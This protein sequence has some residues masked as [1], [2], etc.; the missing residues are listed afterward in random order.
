[1]GLFGGGSQKTTTK[2]SPW[3]PAIPYLKGVLSGAQD[4]YDKGPLKY[5]PGSTVAPQSDGS[6]TAL[7]GI[8]QRGMNGSPVDTAAEHNITGVLNGD[9]LKAGNPYFGAM[10][11]RIMGQ[12]MPA[13]Q[14][15]FSMAGRTGSGLNQEALAQGLGDSIGALAFQNYNSERD[16][17]MDSL[18]LAPQ[19]AHED[20]VNMGNAANAA[21]QQ[22]GYDQRQLTDKVNR[23][24]FEQQAPGMALDQF[25]GRVDPIGGMGSQTTS[26]T[27]GG[28]GGLF[29]NLLGTALVG[30]NIA[31][32]LN[33]FG[34]GA[35]GAAGAAGS[36]PMGLAPMAGMANFGM[37][38]WY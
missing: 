21:Q 7:Q 38:G 3:K 23:W 27:S 5:Y 14:S 22:E 9:F 13:I 10:S 17:Q 19:I 1:M 32:K 26:T 24:N 33:L 6:R 30:S 36:A 20:F 18:G 28:G 4:L 2:V 37:G 15:Q 25:A 31:S 34:A 12:V 16:R 11:D 35:G 8:L 29:G